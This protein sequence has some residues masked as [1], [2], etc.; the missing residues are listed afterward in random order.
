VEAA[1]SIIATAQR[2]LSSCAA[3]QLSG[4]IGYKCINQ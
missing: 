3:A 2:N 1:L 4:N